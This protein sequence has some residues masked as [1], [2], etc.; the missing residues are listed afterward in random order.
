MRPIRGD[1]GVDTPVRTA[2][3]ERPVARLHG[4]EIRPRPEAWELAGLQRFFDQ[5]VT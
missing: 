5:R 2:K 4:V 1:V 3:A